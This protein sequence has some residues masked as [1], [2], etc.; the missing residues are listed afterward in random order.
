MKFKP[1]I[2]WKQQLGFVRFDCSLGQF[3][4]MKVMLAGVMMWGKYK[5][6]EVNVSCLVGNDLW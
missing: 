4:F 2:S 5:T 3:S 1:E 6:K